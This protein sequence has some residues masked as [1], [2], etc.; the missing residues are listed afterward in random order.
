MATAGEPNFMDLKEA[1]RKLETG[2]QGASLAHFADGWNTF[3]L[4]LQG[5]VKRFRGLTTGKAMR[6]PLARLRSIN[7]GN[8]YSTWP[9]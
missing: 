8:G 5:D 3:N 2:D 1:A 7:N 6:L 4:T 9:N